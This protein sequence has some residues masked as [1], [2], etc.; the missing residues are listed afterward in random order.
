MTK[1]IVVFDLDGTL[2]ETAPDLLDSLNHVLAQNGLEMT[3]EDHLRRFVGQ[4]G[5]MMLQR[6]FA[7]AGKPFD[8]E[9]A[10]RLVGEFVAHYGAH[11][12]GKSYPFDGVMA[13]ISAL[14]DQGYIFAICTNKTEALAKKLLRALGIAD[15][16]GAICG[17]DTFPV[18][19]PDPGH[20]L[21]TIE[22]AGGDPARALMVGDSIADIDAA[23][24]A[25]IPV[26][27][28]DF[29]YTDKPVTEL[30][31]TRVISH[32]DAMTPELVSDL[33]AL[34]AG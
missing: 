18:K 24:A 23:L 29:G 4:G 22:A 32:F 10:E 7:A 17:G 33:I 16:F 3:D 8:D 28:V 30:N 20:L 6:A 13:Q 27:A 21:L 1:P 34:K 5:R 14:R 12:P 25:K 31:P 11:M 2:V 9:I 19:K 26:I 15:E